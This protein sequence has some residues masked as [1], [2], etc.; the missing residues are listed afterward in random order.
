MKL[1]KC[2]ECGGEI[3]EKMLDYLLM[4]VKLGRFPT[5]VCGAY[6]SHF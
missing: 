2:P 3:K 1:T 4:G 5:L 6:G